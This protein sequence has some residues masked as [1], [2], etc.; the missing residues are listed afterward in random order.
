M[1]PRLEESNG[2]MSP[3]Q[4]MLCQRLAHAAFAQRIKSRSLHFITYQ[5]KP[6]KL[7]KETCLSH[8]SDIQ[9]IISSD[10]LTACYESVS[11]NSGFAQR[12]DQQRTEFPCKRT[13]WLRAPSSW[14]CKQYVVS[15]AGTWNGIL[16]RFLENFRD[17]CSQARR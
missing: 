5:I 6:P 16:G 2:G 17:A 15:R 14:Y 3:M 9:A 12:N 10:N 11:L 8:V 7:R 13:A 4:P 1:S